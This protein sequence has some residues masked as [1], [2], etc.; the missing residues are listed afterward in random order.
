MTE[1]RFFDRK[2]YLEIIDKRVR[3]LLHGYRQNLAIV[4]DELVG[5]TS[6]IYK[7]LN[8]FYD[9]RTIMVY[10]EA[11]P[12]TLDS[13]ARRFL[14]VLL[15]NFL[16]NSGIELKE[17]LNFLINKSEKYIPETAQKIRLILNSLKKRKK[18]NIFSELLSV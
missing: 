8:N 9:N 14:G 15:Y 2:Q 17:D 7:F 13:F 5:K 18:N 1:D 6:L 4:G 16:L 11:R 10:L 12:E 3:G